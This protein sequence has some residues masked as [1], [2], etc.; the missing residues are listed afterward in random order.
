MSNKV[1]RE[2]LTELIDFYYITYEAKV[3]ILMDLCELL[4]DLVEDEA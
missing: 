2:D 4:G 1:R 3:S